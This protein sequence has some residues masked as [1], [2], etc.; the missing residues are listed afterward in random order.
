MELGSLVPWRDKFRA[1]ANREDIY[2]P[3]AMF[4]RAVDHMFDDFLGAAGGMREVG[5][6]WQGV[7]PTIDVTDTEKELVVTAELPGLDEKDFEVTLAG[8]I[9]TIK[10][11]KKIEHENRSGGVYQLERRFGSFSR[12]LRLPFETTDEQIEARYDKGV[13]TIHLPK[14]PEA[15]RQ[16]RRIEVN[17]AEKAKDVRH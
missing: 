13:L 15:Q 9:L 3:F 11:E 6:G 17:A 4:R 7:S 2:D 12:S 16:V 1:P 10:G 8:D 5:S 14:P